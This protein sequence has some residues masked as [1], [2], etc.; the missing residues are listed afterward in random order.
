M[1]SAL[2]Q[3]AWRFLDS[4]CA[5]GYENMA[6]DE[7]LYISCQQGKAPPTLR[8]YGWRP[9]A[10]SLGYFQKAEAAVD[11][12]ECRRLGIDVVRRMSGGRAVLHN[13]ELTY[14][15]IAPEHRSPFSPRVLETYMTIGACLMKALKSFS[16]N[17]QWVAA[18]D[19]HRR[20]SSVKHET[21]SCFSAPSWYEITVDG[22]KICGSAQKRGNGFFLQ[23]GSILIDHDP[24][25]LA[26]VLMSRKS[27]EAFVKEIADSTTSLNH[28]L[29]SQVDVGELQEKVLTGFEGTLGITLNHGSLTASEIKL[30]NLLLREK[31]QSTAWNLARAVPFTKAF[32]NSSFRLPVKEVGYVSRRS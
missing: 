25:L 20:A 12:Q 16:L 2:Q 11:L 32:T 9:P 1:H 24:E 27:K 15:V 17:V 18:R 14:A 28:H 21:A 22:K 4:P 3:Q 7:A 23:H 6:I 13:H 5:S 31:Y 10:V 8:L 19:K 26:A 30:K 29:S